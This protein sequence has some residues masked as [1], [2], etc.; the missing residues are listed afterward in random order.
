MDEAYMRKMQGINV[1]MA[2]ELPQQIRDMLI[3]KGLTLTQAKAVLDRAKELWSL[4]LF[5]MAV[6]SIGGKPWTT[7]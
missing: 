6:F 7:N 5:R 1:V 3:G 2:Q 4:L